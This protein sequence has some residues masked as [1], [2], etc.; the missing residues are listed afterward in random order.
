MA[1]GL[2]MDFISEFQSNPFGIVLFCEK[3]EVA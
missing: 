3:I 2:G 1:A